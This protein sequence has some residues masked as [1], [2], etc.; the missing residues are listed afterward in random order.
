MLNWETAQWDV[1]QEGADGKRDEMRFNFMHAKR[2]KK[3]EELN[4]Y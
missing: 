4:S 2:E 1:M 3:R